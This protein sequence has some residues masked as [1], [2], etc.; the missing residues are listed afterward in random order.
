M[1]SSEKITERI[2][3]L[4]QD[5]ADKIIA[6]AQK[7]AD[8]ITENYKAKA[9]EISANAEREISEE[10]SALRSRTLAGGEKTKRSTMLAAKSAKIDE[11]FDKAKAKLLSL[12][13]ADYEKMLSAMLV[14]TVKNEIETEKIMIE[15][16]ADGE[17]I[18]VDIYEVFLSQSDKS[19]LTGDFIKEASSFAANSG[20]K[21]LLADT[22]RDIDGGFILKCGDIEVNCSFG[23][24][25]SRL[26]SG[27]E[28][29]VYKI[30]FG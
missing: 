29:D 13:I 12:P 10:S 28:G 15:A 9:A 8:A 1:N 19:R 3:S 30:L 23:L 2:I 21:I 20:K 26:K 11:A 18:P 5:E 24:I 14:S 4:A 6:D 25:L 16:S 27:L 17:I 22:V 7:E